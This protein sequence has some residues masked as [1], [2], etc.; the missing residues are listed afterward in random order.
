MG[1]PS[2]KQID[3]AIAQGLARGDSED[4]ILADV[5]SLRRL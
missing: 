4:A 2:R 1:A 3:E 5:G